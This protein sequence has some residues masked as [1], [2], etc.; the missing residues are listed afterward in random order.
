[1]ANAL[2]A[3]LRQ[4]HQAPASGTVLLCDT[5]SSMSYRDTVTG[6]RRIDHLAEIL[7]ALLSEVR[8][9][10]VYTFDTYVREMKENELP[11]PSGGTALHLGLQGVSKLRPAKV[12]VI[13]DGAVN[14]PAGALAAGRQLGCVIDA[15]YV[16]PDYDSSALR[17]MQE[18]ARSTGG[19]SGKFDIVRHEQ[20]THELKLRITDG[21][22]R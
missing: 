10:A 16:G 18:L 22:K 12:I 14:D 8:V 13:C 20:L 19:V 15:Y 6:R 9:Q 1:M 3:S 21:R 7:S 5:S 2:I 4:R 11:E 17:F